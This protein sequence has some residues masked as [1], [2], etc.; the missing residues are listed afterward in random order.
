[1]KRFFAAIIIIAGL[2]FVF[3]CFKPIDNL[4]GQ[5]SKKLSNIELQKKYNTKYEVSDL[6][7]SL[8]PVGRILE[9]EGWNVWCCSPIYDEK[10]KVHVFFS[11]WPGSHDNWLKNSEIAHA[12]ADKPEGPYRVIGTVL[13]GRGKGYWDANTIH[14]PTIQKV[15]NKYVMFYLGNNVDLA[16]ERKISHA[17]TQRIGLAMADSLNGEWI[18]VSDKNP[19]LDISPNQKDWDSYLTTNPALLQNTDGKFW[20]Y[21]KSWDFNNDKMRKMGLAIADKIEGPYKKYEN[22]PV[23][24]FSS[25]KAQVEDAYVFQYHKKY[26]MVMRDM[27]VIHPHVG[28]MVESEDGINWSA[29]KLGYGDSSIYFGG[30]V[31]RFERPQI[32]MKDGKPEYLFLALMGGRYNTSSGAVLKIDNTKFK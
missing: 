17:A 15:G 10:G 22:N 19:I 25:I 16:N 32:L 4:F 24:S 12:V 11:R 26:Y 5:K 28:L 9:Q 20:L 1:M 18:R 14:N 27:G 3:L 8:S 23:L 13:K 30:K 31:E 29:P 2:G 6:Y 7:N 21:Y